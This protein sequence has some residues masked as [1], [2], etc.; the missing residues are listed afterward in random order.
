MVHGSEHAVVTYICVGCDLR[1]A[2]H[3]FNNIYHFIFWNLIFLRRPGHGPAAHAA[4]SRI[5]GRTAGPR[6]QDTGQTD[7]DRVQKEI[8]PRAHTCL[9]F[10]GDPFLN[11]KIVLVDA[12]PVHHMSFVPWGWVRGLARH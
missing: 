8:T 12:L 9:G 3:L 5:A 11:S 1:V 4:G 10:G 6:V 7:D 2:C